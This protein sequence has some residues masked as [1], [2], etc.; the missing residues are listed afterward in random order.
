MKSTPTERENSNTA[1]LTSSATAKLL[2]L[3]ASFLPFGLY[4][5]ELR[6][7]HIAS[8][9]VLSLGIVELL[10]MML[11]LVLPFAALYAFKIDWAAAE[12]YEHQD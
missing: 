10:A 9:N 8:T 4:I 7:S 3:L 1:E 2:P 11:L 12:D 6:N 5:A